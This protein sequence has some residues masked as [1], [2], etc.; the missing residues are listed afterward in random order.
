MRLGPNWPPPDS[1]SI[2]WNLLS[3]VIRTAFDP[4][5]PQ[6]LH[7]YRSRA[8]RS[9]TGHSSGGK[10]KLCQLII[11]RVEKDLSVLWTTQHQDVNGLN[12][13]DTVADGQALE[14]KEKQGY[15]RK[16]RVASQRDNSEDRGVTMKL[17][18]EGK[19]AVI[20]KKNTKM[21]RMWTHFL[22][23]C[24]SEWQTE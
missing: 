9:A 14:F 2:T 7:H 3:Q 18:C 20:D 11:Y 16:G 12:K 15:T 17:D 24:V 19:F 23:F 8:V 22:P 13:G 10:H 6:H 5:A 21:L 4:V 1:S